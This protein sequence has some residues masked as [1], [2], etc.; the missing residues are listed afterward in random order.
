[1]ASRGSQGAIIA[2]AVVVAGVAGLAVGRLI[3]ERRVVEVSHVTAAVWQRGDVFPSFTLLTEWG[4]SVETDALLARGGVVMFLDL[5]CPP[6]VDMALK[7]DRAVNDGVVTI[8]QVVAITSQ[9][10]AAIARF[11]EEAELQIAV[12]RDPGPAFLENHW[13]TSFP[14]EVIVG[15]DGAVVSVSENPATP[16]DTG[17][18]RAAFAPPN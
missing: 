11:R 6:C 5:E 17:I 7:W 18:L 16:V 9:N 13:I 4:D 3:A 14:V 10:A 1:M 2:V 15:R 12:Y 8:E